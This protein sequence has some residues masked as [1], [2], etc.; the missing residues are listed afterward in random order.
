M[1]F[2]ELVGAIVTSGVIL[3]SLNIVGCLAWDLLFR[4]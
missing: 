2:W 1:D 3:Y 4:K